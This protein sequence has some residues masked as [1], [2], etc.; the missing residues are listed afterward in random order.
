MYC[1]KCGFKLEENATV[2]P[3]C[4]H[5]VNEK[6]EVV[7]KKVK[8]TYHYSEVNKDIKEVKETIKEVK[9]EPAKEYININKTNKKKVVGLRSELGYLNL[10]TQFWHHTLIASVGYIVMYFLIVFIGRGLVSSYKEAGMDFSCVNPDTGDMS[11]C[12]IE[13]TTAYVK[14]SCIAQVVAELLVISMIALLFFRHLVP[15]FK[16]FKQKQTWK[17]YGIGFG[18]M[19]GLTL[20]YS[21]VLQLF[22]LEST[23]TNQ[24]AV[25]TTIL[26]NPLL[27]FVFVVIAAPLFEE[28][29][30]RFGVFRTF[31][32]KNKKTEIIGIII[33]TILFAAVHMEATFISVFEDMSNPNWELLKSDMLS[34]PTYLIGAFALT[35]IYYKSKNLLAS[36]LVHMTWNFMAFIAIVG[37]SFIPET[38]VIK[39]VALNIFETLTRLF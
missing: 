37:T 38:E 13:I 11:A 25:N 4:N 14:I 12:P 10:N 15:F 31:A 6:E 8:T 23:S 30:F 22:N 32:F 24:D 16:Q 1:K 17:W 19:Y 20:I 5:D 36:M 18:L 7:E 27:G 3:F 29:I 28:L 2:C 39:S 21:I 33:T 9:V 35:F 34:L 26:N